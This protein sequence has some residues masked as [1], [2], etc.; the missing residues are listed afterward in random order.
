[1]STNILLHDT[2]LQFIHPFYGTD[3]TT[4]EKVLESAEELADQLLS[5]G[6]QFVRPIK[7]EESPAVSEEA[8]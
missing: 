4:A 5:T 2:K 3:L 1:M 7:R 8:P 6:Q